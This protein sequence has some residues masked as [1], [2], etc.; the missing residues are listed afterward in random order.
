MYLIIGLLIGGIVIS[1]FMAVK[2]GREERESENEW[3]EQEGNVFIARMN[4][5]KERK[6]VKGASEA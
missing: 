5:E 1:G 4:E 6:V 3:I 2:T